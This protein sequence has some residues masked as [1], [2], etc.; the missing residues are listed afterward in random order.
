MR[1]Y[2]YDYISCNARSIDYIHENFFVRH[3][4]ARAGF[5][6]NLRSKRLGVNAGPAQAGAH[7]P[8]RRSPMPRPGD[9]IGRDASVHASTTSGL[10]FAR[11]M[12]FVRRRACWW[13]RDGGHAAHGCICV[14]VRHI[15]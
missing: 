8:S 12:F 4:T 14:N 6:H 2:R 7:P 3:L 13:R 9:A 11:A 15:L 1:V 10:V 5:A